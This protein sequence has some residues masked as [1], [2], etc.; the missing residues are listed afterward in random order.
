M[1]SLLNVALGIV[2]TA[3][4]YFL[5]ENPAENIPSLFNMP[6]PHSKRGS[7]SSSTFPEHKH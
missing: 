3:Y 4:G 6:K 5:I 1:L 7:A 2:D